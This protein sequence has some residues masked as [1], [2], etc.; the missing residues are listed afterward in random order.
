MY[1]K[2]DKR[3]G[4][5]RLKR[6]MSAK[7]FKIAT[8]NPFL[9]FLA[10]AWVLAA[11]QG[12]PESPGVG[13]PASPLCICRRVLRGSNIAL[14]INLR[15]PFQISFAAEC[16]DD[17]CVEVTAVMWPSYVGCKANKL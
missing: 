6:A 3:R 8:L 14:N 7:L 9:S 11:V 13:L 16:T 4:S 10:I 12:Y 2:F 1:V 17:G 15:V 5:T